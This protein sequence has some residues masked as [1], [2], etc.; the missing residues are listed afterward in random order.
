[1]MGATQTFDVDRFAKVRVMMDQGATEGERAAARTRAEAMAQRAGMTLKQ[2]MSK[3]DRKAKAEAPKPQQQAGADWR[4]VFRNFD[5][6]MEAKEP[7]YKARKAKENAERDAERTR[8]RAEALKVH[9]SAAAIF[10]LTDIERALY[11]AA[12]PYAKREWYDDWIEGRFAFTQELG[13]VSSHMWPER[14]PAYVHDAIRNAWPM[15]DTLRDVLAELRM[16]DALRDLR[17]LFIDGEYNR[18]AEVELR[19]W[20]L[21]KALDE[22]PARDLNDV[23]ARL[24]WA[25]HREPYE[26][27]PMVARLLAD[28]ERLT[29]QTEV[30]PASPPP[31][32]RTNSDKRRDVLSMMDAHPELSD[33]EISR[34]CGVSPQ[35]VSTWRK[36]RAGTAGA[37][38]Q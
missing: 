20:L 21:A 2:A 17:E 1:M 8:Q 36:K 15:P 9:G 32:R 29:A 13:G 16:W 22:C 7:G 11:D 28:L 34:R 30:K 25:Q 35:T 27:K 31:Q 19:V 38:T 5:D 3:V 10:A 4:D 33:R 6:W 26:Y 37:R 14:S 23:M 12:T 18:H 24:Q